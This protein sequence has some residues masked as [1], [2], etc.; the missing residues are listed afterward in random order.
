MLL[1]R[2]VRSRMPGI[3]IIGMV[4]GA[5]VKNVLVNLVGDGQRVELLAQLR[6]QLQ[7]LAVEHA[8]GGIIRRVDDDRLGAR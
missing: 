8:A 6:N 4:L 1:I 3:C 5:V 2:M 7:A